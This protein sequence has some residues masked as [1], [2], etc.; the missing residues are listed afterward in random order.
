MFQVGTG[1]A[2]VVV[3]SYVAYGALGAILEHALAPYVR[4]MSRPYRVDDIRSDRGRR[5][6]RLDHYWH[7]SRI[8]VWLIT[9]VVAWLLC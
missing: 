9:P 7:K 6:A 3:G 2:V 1:C 5:L 4:E 8:V